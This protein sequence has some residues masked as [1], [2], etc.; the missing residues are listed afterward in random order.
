VTTLVD[1]HHR[2]AR[3]FGN[4]VAR[5]GTHQWDA[6]TPCSAWTVRDLV[7][8]LT[9]EALWT[10]PL[11]AGRTIEEV[12]ET[13]DG[14]V[15]GDDPRRAHAGAV[16]AAIEAV[17]RVELTRTVHLSFGEVPARVYIEQLFTDHLVHTWD[18]ARAIGHDERLPEDLV[19]ACLA[20]FEPHE[21]D[22]RAAGVIGPR[23]P[24]DRTDPQ[25]RLLAAFGRDPHPPTTAA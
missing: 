24:T 18:L 4:L 14:D 3:G 6:P 10:P 5:I 19:I 13:F 21:D 7:N 9:S 25:A 8:H 20:V 11:L 17:D 15:L 22:Y 16:A 23:V 12:G 1:H 2:A